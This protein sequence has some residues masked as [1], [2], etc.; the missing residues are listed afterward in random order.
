MFCLGDAVVTCS[1]QNIKRWAVGC[2]HLQVQPHH[3]L[4]APTRPELQGHPPGTPSGDTVP[5]GAAENV[6]V[7]PCRSH[8]C[9]W[10]MKKSQAEGLP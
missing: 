6:F 2:P 1:K 10:Q 7:L 3:S 8:H 5:S 4:M 9:L